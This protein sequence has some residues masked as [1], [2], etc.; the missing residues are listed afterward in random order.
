MGEGDSGGGNRGVGARVWDKG[1]R[2]GFKERGA[3]DRCDGEGGR[4]GGKSAAAGLREAAGVGGASLRG[5][6]SHPPPNPHR[7]W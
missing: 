4:R 1:G 6:T 2:D 7:T 5:L 3:G